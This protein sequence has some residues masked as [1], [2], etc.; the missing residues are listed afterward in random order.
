M[1]FGDGGIG[2]VREVR[3]VSGLP[4]GSSMERLD[5]LNDD[6]HVMV[7]SIIGGDHMLAN[8]Q[9]TT[10]LVQ[11]KGG[12]T[13]VVESYVV[14]VPVGSSKEDTCLFADTIIGCNLRSLAKISEEIAAQL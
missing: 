3:V 12:K 4:G 2:S 6:L 11:T 10:K 5:K 8:Y 7:F 13:E 1:T 14:D 9:S